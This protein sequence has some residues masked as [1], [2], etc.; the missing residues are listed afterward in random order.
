MNTV[1]SIT[2][3]Q[4]KL[5]DK[6]EGSGWDRALRFFIRSSDF[7][8]VIL[9]LQKERGENKRFTPGINEIFR[10]FQL[11]PLPELKVIFVVTEPWQD[12]TANNGLALSH[13]FGLLIKPEFRALYEELKRTVPTN[14]LTDGDLTDWARQGVLLLNTTPTVRIGYPNSHKKIW[15]D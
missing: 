1:P 11:C 2:E 4:D 13:N 10:C 15:A 14:I 6:L 8:D 7:Y 12:A 9:S 5:F 3:I